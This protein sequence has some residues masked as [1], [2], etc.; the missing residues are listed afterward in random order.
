MYWP[1]WR[2][3]E[4]ADA[5][6]ASAAGG[7]ESEAKG[8]ERASDCRQ[9]PHALGSGSGELQVAYLSP[10]RDAGSWRQDKLRIGV[11]WVG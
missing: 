3:L 6:A 11:L 7:H 4:S 8:E 2:V 1:A 10:A 5:C 9:K